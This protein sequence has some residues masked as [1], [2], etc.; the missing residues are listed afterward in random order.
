MS[1]VFLG[2][3][4][5]DAKIIY[6]NAARANSGNGTTWGKA[7]K[8]LQDAL[9]L[10]KPGDSLYL[11]AGT[12]YPDDGVPDG[13]GDREISFVV[14]RL[15]IYGGFAG[16]ESSLAQRDILANETILSG[17][18]WPVTPETQGYERYWSLHVVVLTSSSTFDGVTIEKGRANGDD[19]PF[20]QG[21]GIL[22][23][24]GTTVTMRNC[25]VRGNLATESGA[26]VWGNVVATNC[27]FSDNLVNNEQLLTSIVPRPRNWLFNQNGSG[28]AIKGNVNAVN[29]EF[30]NNQLE[31]QCL[32]LGTSSSATGG[33]ISGD[34]VRVVGCVFDENGV[35]STSFNFPGTG[36]DA[37]ARGGAISAGRI[38]ATNCTF[39]NNDAIS[40]AT[41]SVSPDPRAIAHYTAYPTSLGGAVAGQITAVN[42]SFD[43]NSTLTEAPMG[44]ESRSI[45]FG[46]ALYVEDASSVTN[47]TVTENS[48]DSIDETEKRGGFIRTRGA[49]HIAGGSVTPISQ[50]TFMDN[51][52]STLY[53][54]GAAI[55]AD[56]SVNIISNIIWF[57]DAAVTG[58]DKDF[59][60]HVGGKARISNRLYPTPSTETINQVK[61][62][63]SSITTAGG[64]N[65][66]VGSPPERT[67]IN[68]DPEFAEVTDPVGPDLL[69]RTEDDGLRLTVASP[70]VG[71]GK[72]LFLPKDTADLDSDANL[73]ETVPLDAVGFARIQDAALDLGAY[74][75]GNNLN[76]PDIQVEQP[77]GT[78]LVDGAASVDFS[79]FPGIPTSFVIRN[80]GPAE[81]RNLVVTVTGADA[82]KFK[83]TQPVIK[84][85]ASG[86]TTTFTVTFKPLVT[87]DHVAK[88][89]IASNDPDE[90]PFD[91]DVE[92]NS[93]LPD[94]GVELPVGTPLTDGSS[95]I[96]FGNVS[97]ASRNSKTFTVTNSGLGDLSLL[98]M[99]S[100]GPNAANFTIG[101]PGLTLV[102][103]G[104]TT[105]F[106]VFFKPSGT[107]L[108][109]A[110]IVVQSNDPDA[111]SLFLINVKGRG[112]GA[113]EIVVSQ[114]FSPELPDGSTNDF[115]SVEIPSSY[116]KTFIIKNNGSAALSEIEI[117]LTGGTAFK[118]T[119][120]GKTSIGPGAKAEF[121]VTFKPATVGSKTAELQIKSNDANESQIDITL[122]GTGVTGSPSRRPSLLAAATLA[123]APLG[124]EQGSGSEGA[125]TVTTAADGLKYLVLTVEKPAAAGRTVEVSSNLMDWFS[126]SKHTTTLLD[127][128]AV[129]EVRDNTPVKA[130][131]KRYIRLK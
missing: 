33:A 16:N 130:G 41:A 107:G 58:F 34:T 51:L 77:A 46:S 2:C 108:K 19:A 23:P 57:S 63:F 74:E 68:L 67:F 78:P 101:A 94:I 105:T 32:D 18:I 8:F 60:I 83:I 62:G 42:C 27:T 84:T 43:N 88:I 5:A 118:M 14:D 73:A 15:Q 82:S 39:S 115:G 20:S 52:T 66:D 26:A 124:A 44:D 87:R 126:G 10:A 112:V 65:V 128:A 123:A 37:T 125:V 96:N 92:G 75:L 98:G 100:T 47:C 59:L 56:G 25:T 72:P 45:S 93:L 70:A 86:T 120:L 38:T 4:A 90:S 36:S 31:V 7:C 79:G 49:I 80:T 55:S 21:G 113:P 106:K 71:K 102:P 91:I 24:S 116:S 95:E 110:S 48:V 117:S 119:P 99:T 53:G 30:L 111:E 17:E 127:N 104:G 121:I 40:Y 3:G 35:S 50:S 11:A 12:Y 64:A 6:V 69:W 54:L 97:E 13:F 9:E 22:A 89:S 129:L 76:S 61:G 122:V 29:C 28:G 1:A 109:T 103:P 85:V 114:P 131:E 81:L